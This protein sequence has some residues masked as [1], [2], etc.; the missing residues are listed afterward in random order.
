MLGVSHLTWP[1]RTGSMDWLQDACRQGGMGGSWA[2]LAQQSVPQGGGMP[3]PPRPRA[4]GGNHI[5]LGLFHFW[6]RPLRILSE[7]FPFP[8]LE[9][10][11][12][13][14]RFVCLVFLPSLFP[15]LHSYPHQKKFFKTPVPP[16]DA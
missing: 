14:P 3:W 6:G 13:L 5:Q 12:L 4:R 16:T 11:A 8:F 15:V 2:L 7:R 1:D 10:L 9:L